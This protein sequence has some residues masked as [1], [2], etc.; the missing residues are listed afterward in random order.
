MSGTRG[1]GE[2]RIRLVDGEVVAPVAVSPDGKRVVVSTLSGDRI[3]DALTGEVLLEFDPALNA[4]PFRPVWSPSGDRIASWQH[5]AEGIEVHIWNASN[6]ELLR[7]FK[8]SSG[9]PVRWS[10]DG[11]RLAVLETRGALKA[12]RVEDGEE[13]FAVQAHDQAVVATELAWSPDGD[14]LATGAYDGLIKVWDTREW[15]LLLTLAGES[16]VGVGFGSR[17]GFPID[18]LEFSP[19]GKRIAVGDTSVRIWDAETGK[20]LIR[21]YPE[22][23]A[24]YTAI[25]NHQRREFFAGRSLS[26]QRGNR[27]NRE[28]LGRRLR[29]SGVGPGR[30]FERRLDGGPWSPDGNQFATASNDGRAIVW[31]RSTGQE[32]VRFEGHRHGTVLS[33]DYSPDGAEIVTSGRDGSVRAWDAATGVQLYELP[34]RIEPFS[35]FYPPSRPV[36]QVSYSPRGD[37]IFTISDFQSYETIEVWDP[38]KG[39]VGIEL[40]SSVNSAAWSPDGRRLAVASFSQAY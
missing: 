35:S 10:P 28:D 25:W 21:R 29:G 11:A 15:M 22:E 2:E 24:E 37:R 38:A 19:D 9:G 34:E 36:V 23:G 32:V 14:R 31:D 5:A 6:G 13:L 20:E 12:W 17:E 16:D 18:D 33:L 8:L 26:R 39:G 7:G 1:D 27:S 40:A 3:L 30:L 4:R